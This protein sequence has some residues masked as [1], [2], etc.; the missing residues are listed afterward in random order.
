MSW[1]EAK[2]DGIP[3]AK[4]NGFSCYYPPC[5]ICGTPVY[6]WSYIRGVAYTCGE[7]RKELVRLEHV[8]KTEKGKREKLD[9]AVKRISKQTD[10]KRYDNAIRKVELCLG[11]RGWFQ[12]TEEIMTALELLRKGYEV[13]HQTRIYDYKV[14]FIIPNLKV[15]LEIDGSI[16]HGKDKQ[17]QQAIRDEVIAGKLGPGW[18]VIHIPTDNI[19]RNVTRLVPAIKAV[20]RYRQKQ[21]SKVQL[22]PL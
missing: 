3:V 1:I 11:H 21:D 6:S 4:K 19:N 2:E 22:S 20:L 18:Q 12:S 13:H 14:D 5:H 17:R 15:A 8:E 9:K 10:I 7:C 16:Y